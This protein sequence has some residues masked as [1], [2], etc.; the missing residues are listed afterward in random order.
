VLEAL[1]GRHPDCRENA[2]H[3][4]ASSNNRW[5]VSQGVPDAVFGFGTDVIVNL[6]AA[7]NMWGDDLSDRQARGFLLLGRLKPSLTRRHARADLQLLWGHL[8]AAYP[9]AEQNRFAELTAA[10]VLS[11]DEA[12]KARLA[13]A[14]LI[15]AALLTLFIACANASNLLI[16]L[17][18]QRRREALIKSALGAARA[19]LVGEF[20]RETM[21]LCAAAGLAGYGIAS[22]ALGWLSRFDAPVPVFGSREI[23]A[24]LHPGALVAAL[25]VA[26]IV[27]ASLASGLA[28]AL[29]ASKPDLASALNAEVAIGGRRRGAIRNTVVVV[30]VAVCTLVL[31]GTGICLRS[32][33]NLRQ[34][35]PG[36][37]AR[38]IVIAFPEVLALPEFG[39]LP[40]RQAA[41]LHEEV[42]RR[43]GQIGGVESVALVRSLPLGDRTWGQ[44]FDREEIRFTD[45]PESARKTFVDSTVADEN[46]FSTLGIALLAGR[47]FRASDVEQSPPVIVVN[48]FMA[49]QFW[50]RQDPIGRTVRVANGGRPLTVVGVA[51][52]GKY[53][54]LGEAGRPVMYY[55]LNQRYHGDLTLIA[56]TRGDPRLWVEPISRAIRQAGI[57]LWISPVTME[58]WM[59]ATLFLPLLI[60]ACVGGL[61]ILGILL[62]AF[63]LYGAV[64]YSFSERRKEL[65]IRIALG[66]RPGQLMRMVVRETSAVVW[67]GVLVGLALAVAAAASFRSRFYGIHEAEWPV[68]VPVATVVVAA[69]F[70]IAIA[71]T[72]RWTRMNPMD[73]VRHT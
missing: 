2:E 20:L 64:S 25:T 48:H 31:A 60:S 45:R 5:C 15:A 73:A 51:A 39:G 65:G 44:F 53:F 23:A 4:E 12:G 9:E 26:L 37:S 62:A 46:Y 6:G 61:G 18:T 66:A 34:V 22:A 63:G 68:L 27:M 71:A 47:P 41:K 16:A 70:A 14:V 8:A 30:Q 29:Y 52:D 11:P 69:S 50:P 24:D 43:V 72:R 54:D 1:G 59:N 19:R 42:R 35:N 28:P 7:A 13:A 67:F 10:T 33:H 55:A 58:T 40:P 21:V 36:F 17:A 32:L 49:E 38:N 57:K 3:Q 56:R